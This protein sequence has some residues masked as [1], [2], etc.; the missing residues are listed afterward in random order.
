M[1]SSRILYVA[2]PIDQSDY[3]AWK[4][5]VSSVVRVATKR[6][7]IAYRPARAFDCDKDTQ[8]G[9]E[10]ETVN[11]LVLAG[12]GALVAH[13]P[14]GVPTIG[15][16]R[17]IEWAMANA[18]PTLV[19]SDGKPG[20]SLSDVPVIEL[21]DVPTFGSWLQQVEA[22][23]YEYRRH[24]IPFVLDGGTL[25]T[26]ANDGDAG[27][28]L[29]VSEDRVIEP[30]DFE[31]VPCGLRVALPPGVW[32]RITGRS[33]TL[34]KR[35]LMVAEGIIDTGYRGPLYTGVW[36]LGSEPAEVRKGERI[37]QLKIGRAHV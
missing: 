28:D 16:P 36:N 26:R 33:S 32:A 3:G 27:Y 6:G 21:G 13:L 18:V 31:D 7:W 17:E 12:S 14:M 29:Y 20:W 9:P 11:R 23:A 5:S 2:E 25:P 15:T 8:V 35:H 24:L 30:S 10:I 34:R 1:T 22:G 4:E 19:V 37:A